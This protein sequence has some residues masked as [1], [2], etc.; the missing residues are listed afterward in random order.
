[1][2]MTTISAEIP[3]KLREQLDEADVNVDEVVQ[4]ALEDEIRDWRR[5]DLRTRAEGL[6]ASMTREEIAAAVR[7]S[8]DGK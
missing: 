1:M 7:S 6:T 8:R 3:E 5:S 4:K 2:E